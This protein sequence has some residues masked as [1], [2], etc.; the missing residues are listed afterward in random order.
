MPPNPAEAAQAWAQSLETL[1]DAAW[2]RLVRGVRDKR[3]PA[4][5]VTLSTYGR[6][7]WPQARIVVLRG[8]DKAA[9]TL[10]V[11]TDLRSAKIAELQA[12]P[13]AMLHVWDDRARLQIRAEARAEILTGPQ[14]SDRW[15]RI[16]EGSRIAYGSRPAPGQ[17]ILT[18]LDYAK[19]PSVQDFAVLILHV[20]AFDLVHLGSDH[21][22]AR[23]ERAG[24]W[25]GAWLS[26]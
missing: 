3:A 11:H 15:A 10:E 21:R 20:Q 9:A 19:Q 4:R 22:R 7:G 13:R 23:F 17:P 8:A 1:R 6:N 5:H 26:P 25:T 24:G 16:P 14:V 2:G 18:A 12:D